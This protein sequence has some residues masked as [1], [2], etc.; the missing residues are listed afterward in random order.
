M[1]LCEG[2]Q[3]ISGLPGASRSV[4]LGCPLL[5]SSCR[6]IRAMSSGMSSQV[7]FIRGYSGFNTSLA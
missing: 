4:K 3:S 6:A 1:S 2:R 5:R 7:T